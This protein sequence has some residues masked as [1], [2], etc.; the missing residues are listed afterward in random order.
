MKSMTG[1]I[2]F[3]DFIPKA[4]QTGCGPIRQQKRV[5]ILEV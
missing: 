5:L 4:V 2:L 3:G 1:Q